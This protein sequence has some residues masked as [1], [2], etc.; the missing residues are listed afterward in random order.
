MKSDK[1][2]YIV[3]Q[4]AAKGSMNS[5]INT[6]VMNTGKEFIFELSEENILVDG[7]AMT[8]TIPSGYSF[9]GKCFLIYKN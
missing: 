9:S 8:L 3:G 5:L 7:D 2:Q 6:D 4:Y 1:E